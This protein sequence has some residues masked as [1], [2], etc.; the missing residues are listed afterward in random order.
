MS[1]SIISYNYNE[2]ID[3]LYL[4]IVMRLESLELQYQRLK[5]KR[6]E[7]LMNL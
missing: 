2:W 4:A 1:H 5:Q 7:L 3:R 6:D